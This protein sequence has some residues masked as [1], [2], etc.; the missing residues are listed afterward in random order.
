MKNIIISNRIKKAKNIFVGFFS[1]ILMLSSCSSELDINVD[2][3]NPLTV[4]NNTLLTSSEVNL[5]YIIGGEATRMP[6]NIVQ[7]YAGHRGQ[8]NEYARYDITPSSTDGLWTNLYNVLADLK[9]IENNT[10]NTNDKLYLGIS[11]LLQVYTFS[12][13]TDAFGDIPYTEALQLSLNINPKYDK[14]EAIYDALLIL[15]DSGTANVSTNGGLKPGSADIIYN[16]SS[17]KWAAFGNSLKLRLLNHISLRR[18]ALALAFLQTN[19]I[20]ISSFKNDAKVV[21]GVSANN[22]NPI[23]QF[24]ILSGRKDNAVSNTIVDKM[25]SLSDP[26]ILVYFKPI[27]NGPLI[28][29]I[30]GNIPGDDQDDSG[31][32]SFSRTGTAYAST[33]S[34][35]I[36]LSAAEVNFIK[37]EVY[38]RANSSANALI[39]YN[40]AITQD[41]T[42]LELSSSV[43]ATYLANPLVSYDNTLQRI[44]EQKWITMFQG[45]YES[46]VDWRRTGFPVLTPSLNNRTN[47]IIP[48]KL[49]YPQIEIN[50]NTASL[51][52]GPG[53]PVPYVSLSQKVWWDL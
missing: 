15:V 31:E 6:A 39:S 51:Q 20:L 35:V 24:D 7:H 30:I 16:G 3:N 10:I 22:A 11:Q 32:S 36:L 21:F 47:D 53:I 43:I 27:V 33:D 19:P 29:Q 1:A 4:P 23:Y 14:Q 37:A 44:M 26:R 13:L 48:T 46:W 2:P 42:S 49:S 50:V 45:S 12:V 28:G 17:A 9:A 40:D 41:L 52:A 5:G 34:P 8:P 25:K 38:F 18:P